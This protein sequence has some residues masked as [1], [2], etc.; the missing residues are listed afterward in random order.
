MHPRPADRPS[1]R[2]VCNGLATTRWSSR[3]GLTAQSRLSQ[4]Y[5]LCRFVLAGPVPLAC[6]SWKSR[7]V[8]TGQ[9]RTMPKR[10]RPAPSTA[11]AGGDP[12]RTG[13]GSRGS[14][15]EAASPL[16]AQPAEPVPGRRGP[17]RPERIA[18]P[19]VL[20]SSPNAAS[21]LWRA[22][23]VVEAIRTPSLAASSC[24]SRRAARWRGC[25]GRPGRAAGR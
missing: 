1:C 11:L 5:R 20:V 13:F 10:R 24:R 2:D 3:L 19:L 12:G 14:M 22:R 23:P 8:S 4:R 25:Q 17:E 7:A 16:P 21:E 18:S 6:H 9:P 15:V